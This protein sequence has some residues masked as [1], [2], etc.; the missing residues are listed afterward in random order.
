MIHRHMPSLSEIRH[1]LALAGPVLLAQW[2]QTLVVVVDTMMSGHYNAVD[3]S[4]VAIGGS[5]W[6]PMYLAA[7]GIISALTP[8]IAQLHG[9]QRYE[10]IPRNTYQAAYIAILILPILMGLGYFFDPLLL[11]IN[12]DAQVQPIA[13]AYLNALFWGLPPLLLFN[14]LRCYSDGVSLTK[15]A[16]TASF[17]GLIINVPLNYA[18]IYGKFGLPELGGVGCGWASAIS[19]YVMFFYMAYVICKKEYRSFSLFSATYRWQWPELR[20]IF[21]IGLPIGITF[22]IEA[23]MFGVIALFLA[24]LGPVIVAAHQ[25]ALNVATTL[26]MIP[27]SLGLALTI[28]VGFLLGTQDHIAVRN[29]IK[30]GLG[31]AAL[32]AI[33]AAITLFLFRNS[34]PMLYTSNKHVIELSASLL[35]FAAL[36]QFADAL[37]VTSAG[38]LRGYKDTKTPLFI[39]ALTFWCFGL[40]LGY[41][42]GLTDFFGEAIH[43][44]GFWI[45]LVAG[46]AATCVLLLLRLRHIIRININE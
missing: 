5:I 31:M 26:F 4:A 27:L 30:L 43:A 9:A 10:E 46:L 12:A 25:I 1:L 23:S 40:P 32:Y 14:V 2:L 15:P 45:G 42:L 41:V 11:W 38:A 8:V 37:Q 29:S 22:F 19:F 21:V 28:R 6:F 36:F 33:V 7:I 20:H 24:P 13:V 18:L 16:V 3:L 44:S 35:F 34:I 39:V 17:I